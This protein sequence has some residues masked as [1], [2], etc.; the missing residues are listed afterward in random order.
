MNFIHNVFI[1]NLLCLATTGVDQSMEYN[2]MYSQRNPN[3]SK[4]NYTH[5]YLNCE[6]PT[7]YQLGCTTGKTVVLIYNARCMSKGWVIS[8]TF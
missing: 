6:I 5:A 1:W 4:M 2:E 8:C 7:I 3:D